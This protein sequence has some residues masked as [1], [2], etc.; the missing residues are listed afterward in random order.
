MGRVVP[1]G[2]HRGMFRVA[3]SRDRLSDFANLAHAK[4]SA[5]AAAA[6]ELE[7]EARQRCAIAPPKCPQNGGCFRASSPPI[8]PIDPAG[9]LRPDRGKTLPARF[10]RGTT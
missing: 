7:F 4:D 3:L 9:G 5:L 10:R 8:A 6:R 1:D 2:Q